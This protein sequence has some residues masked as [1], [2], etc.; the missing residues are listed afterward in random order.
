MSNDTITVAEQKIEREALL[1]TSLAHP[2]IIATF[3]I[4]RMSAGSALGTNKSGMSTFGG[5]RTSGA[6]AAQRRASSQ[7]AGPSGAESALGL[8]GG[9]VSRD[10]GSGGSGRGSSRGGSSS[11]NG[12]GR[13]PAG[14]RG[15]FP[16]A[17]T[18]AGETLSAGNSD[19][20]GARQPP[21]SI[22]GPQ[23]SIG[24]AGSAESFDPS[25]AVI[26]DMPGSSPPN[27]APGKG[28]DSAQNN[29]GKRP[30]QQGSH[31][32]DLELM[33]EEKENED[34]DDNI[35]ERCAAA[36]LPM[37]Q[38]SPSPVPLRPRFHWE[39]GPQH[40]KTAAL[41]TTSAYAQACYPSVERS[42]LPLCSSSPKAA[43][44]YFNITARCMDSRSLRFILCLEGAGGISD[45]A[46]RLGGQE[47]EAAGDVVPDGV[48]GEG[49]ACRRAQSGQV[50]SAQWAARY[51]HRP[52]LPH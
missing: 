1:A 41:I 22:R 43:D 11:S 38:T 36:S 5:P 18:P 35:E 45:E 23:G 9:R 12:G 10:A 30:Q 46:V 51:F 39:L 33:P 8:Y 16:I 6:A 37:R 19:N 4:C 50:Q 2:N 42:L 14:G 28:S 21:S 3:K 32:D 47:I 44:A 24:T 48:C 13:R 40:Q 27:T 34:D 20:A 49:L 7:D 25:T 15:D 29:G 52:Q 17:G 26:V 31:E